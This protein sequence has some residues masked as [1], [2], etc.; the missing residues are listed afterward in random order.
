MLLFIVAVKEAKEAR[1]QW[2]HCRWIEPELTRQDEIK[3]L[4]EF[5]RAQELI[6]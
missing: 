1:S 6:D 2:T 5:G 3:R 4:A